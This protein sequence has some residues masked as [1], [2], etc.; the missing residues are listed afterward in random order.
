MSIIPLKSWQFRSKFLIVYALMAFCI[1]ISFITRAA[2]FVTVIDKE[3][4]LRNLFGVIIIGFLY[5]L[6]I[7]ILFVLPVVIHLVFQNNFV[8]RKSVFPF[9]LVV[10]IICILLL[11]F[12]DIIPRDFSPELHTA[13]I[14]YLVLRLVIYI[15]LFLRPAKVRDTWRNGSLYFELAL[16]V[17]G[18]LLNAVS[19]WEF[20]NE[21]T[22]RYNFIAVDYLV[23]THEVLG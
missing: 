23:Y 11:A 2:L 13:F 18:L 15:V 17:F 1:G 14:L 6:V 9:V 5:D 10:A 20:W 4:P 3:I 16:I 19:E 22:S 7:S 21:F 12:T 8:Y